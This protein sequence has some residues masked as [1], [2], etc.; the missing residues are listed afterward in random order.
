MKVSPLLLTASLGKAEET[1]IDLVL[2]IPS[3]SL[4]FHWPF[5]ELFQISETGSLDTCNIKNDSHA[6]E[7]VTYKLGQEPLVVTTVNNA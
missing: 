3:P 5:F 1:W 7:T 6:E 2:F 4:L